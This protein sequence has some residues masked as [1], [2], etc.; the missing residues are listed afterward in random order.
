MDLN[1]L[2]HRYGVSLL[3]ADRATSK[4]ASTVHG[5]LAAAY[6]TRIGDAL[7]RHQQLAV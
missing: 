2:Y 1:Y 3:M 4:R 6:A 7:R 5:E